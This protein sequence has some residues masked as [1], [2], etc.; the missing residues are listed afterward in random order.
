MFKIELSE[1]E[2][3]NAKIHI[4]NNYDKN[5]SKDCLNKYIKY[6]NYIKVPKLLHY[7]GNNL[8]LNL[9]K[10]KV[11]EEGERSLSINYE[12]KQGI[13]EKVIFD[14]QDINTEYLYSIVNTRIDNQVI[15]SWAST[16]NND[17]Y[18]NSN[19]NIVKRMCSELTKLLK[20]D[21]N[22]IINVFLTIFFI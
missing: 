12:V 18:N 17:N 14:D 3:Q 1:S 13:K 8:S 15:Q 21:N 22:N 19:I 20:S 16:E 5:F 2:L 9:N 10:C 11:I 7:I 4:K 6:I